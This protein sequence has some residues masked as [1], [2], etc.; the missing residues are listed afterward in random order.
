MRLLTNS[1]ASGAGVTLVDCCCCHWV[2]SGEVRQFL[3][4]PCEHS[5]WMYLQS[6]MLRYSCRMPLA[7]AGTLFTFGTRA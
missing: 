1:P 7:D 6:T 3:V 2:K 5:V 4:V